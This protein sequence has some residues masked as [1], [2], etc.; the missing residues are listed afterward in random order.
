MI[1]NGTSF[2]EALKSAQ[3]NGYAEADRTADIEGY[4]ACRK[5]AILADL[6]FGRH[7]YPNQI[8]TQ[9]ISGVALQDVEYA[10]RLGYKIKLLG[11]ALRTGDSTV[12]A[13]VAPHLINKM[14]LLSNVD[15]VF[16]GIVV[17]GNAIG[18]AM[19]YGPGA[20]KLPTA[21]AVVA[22]IIDCAKHLKARKY[23]DWDDGAPDY[24]TDSDLLKSRWYIRTDASLESIGAAFGNVK[25]ISMKAAAEGEYA[26]ATDNMSGEE[27]KKR[28]AG[29]DILS[30][31]RIL[32]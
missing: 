7:V 6:C 16:N 29:M 28:T 12:T 19:F 9:G 8:K 27:I 20:G 26:F 11:R 17:H 23:L 32:D 14:S 1:Q 3:K 24:V 25:F 13:Y 10:R 31:F 21:S 2:E 22:D 18:E 15:G 5:I 30:M 4:D